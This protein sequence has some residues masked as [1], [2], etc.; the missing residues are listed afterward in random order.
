M[1]IKISEQI[2]SHSAG[3]QFQSVVGTRQVLS[4]LQILG[5]AGTFH[6]RDN[7]RFVAG[8]FLRKKLLKK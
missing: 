5:K 8:I 4:N 1:E 6:D 7:S 3:K 2:F